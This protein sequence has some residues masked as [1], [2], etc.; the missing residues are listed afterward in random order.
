MSVCVLTEVSDE[1]AGHL[2]PLDPD[3]Y[4]DLSLNDRAWELLRRL[5]WPSAEGE[6][7]WGG[8]RRVTMR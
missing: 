6:P 1:T 2:T 3:G 8:E 5:G 7:G 4:G